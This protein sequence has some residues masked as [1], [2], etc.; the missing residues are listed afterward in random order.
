VNPDDPDL[1]FW[2]LTLGEQSAQGRSA[3]DSELRAEH[4]AAVAGH[5]LQ[6]ETA[7]L[8]ELHQNIAELEKRSRHQAATVCGFRWSQ[9]ITDDLAGVVPELIAGCQRTAGLAVEHRH[10]I[11]TL[12]RLPFGLLASRIRPMPPQIRPQPKVEKQP[13]LVGLDRDESVYR[14]ARCLVVRR[15]VP[16]RATLPCV[17][18]GGRGRVATARRAPRSP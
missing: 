2:I 14:W 15:L 1:L 17:R 7:A 12:T 5:S 13:Q 11:G 10:S 4:S 8:P 6:C 16:H 18:A 9:V 3:L